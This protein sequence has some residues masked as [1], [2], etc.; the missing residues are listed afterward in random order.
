MSA[1][2]FFPILSHL[3]FAGLGGQS[4]TGLRGLSSMSL[5]SGVHRDTF[6]KG[7]MGPFFP[8]SLA[9]TLHVSDSTLAFGRN[10][11]VLG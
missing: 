8:G 6:R 4:G 1:S 5:L 2:T 11:G 3:F 10:L 9:V 7:E